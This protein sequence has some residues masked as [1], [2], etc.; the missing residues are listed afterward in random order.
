MKKLIIC[1]I[2]AICAAVISCGNN[3]QSY[4]NDASADSTAVMMPE[5]VDTTVVTTSGY[6]TFPDAGFSITCPA[7]LEINQNFLDMA[8]QQGNTT[9]AFAYAGATDKDDPDIG[10]IYNINISDWNNDS[11]YSRLSQ[12]GKR[13]SDMEAL[14]DYASNL[15]KNGIEHKYSNFCGERALLYSFDQM[16]LPTMAVFFYKNGRGYL[17][18]V[19]TRQD[20]ESKFK[21]FMQSFELI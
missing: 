12:S 11:E 10:C 13:N 20:L 2:L 1:S 4:N 3:A 18:Q 16:G 6:Q 17:L 8:R 7:E 14:D 21:S 15:V 9:M 19:A 5:A